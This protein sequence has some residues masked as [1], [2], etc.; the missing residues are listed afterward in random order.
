MKKSAKRSIIVSAVLAIIMCV[1]LA[2]GATFAL[3][4]SESKVNISVSSGKVNVVATVD[5][6][7]TYSGQNLTG[8]V[9]EDADKIK[10]T[11][12]L[13][14]TNGTFINGG[15]AAFNSKDANTLELTNMTPG[16]KVTF[17]I[18]VKN[19]SNVAIKY[20]T[21]IM[22]EEDNGLFDGLVID[23]KDGETTAT[24]TT[25]TDDDSPAGEA[26]EE[27]NKAQDVLGMTVISKW[28]SL[29]LD[30]DFDPDTVHVTIDLPSDRGNKY[31]DKNC[32]ISYVVEAIQGNAA[33]ENPDSTTL[34]LYS[35]RDLVKV[36]QLANAKDKS[37][38]NYTTFKLMSDVTLTKQW[39][40]IN[41]TLCK[42]AVFD[43]QGH[44]IYSMNV[45]GGSDNLGFFGTYNQKLTVKD[46][47]F[48]NAKV[49]GPSY[50]GV[51]IGYQYGQVTL[52]NVHVMNSTVETFGT[53]SG[54]MGGLIGFSGTHDGATLTLTNCSVENSKFLNGYHNTCGLVGSLAWYT[55]TPQ[56][57][58][59]YSI[60]DCVVS[61]CH[62]QWLCAANATWKGNNY[63]TCDIGAN[64]A[65]DAAFNGVTAT[66]NTYE[67]KGE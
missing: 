16:D 56:N 30:E 27:T 35:E 52:D 18:T 17:D 53:S 24:G 6:L 43:G 57:R 20:R 63:S 38:Q 23:F 36:A 5:N 25:V 4:T 28:A 7:Q 8:K 55:T 34:Y 10:L 12:E 64:V 26:T 37:I 22:C 46:L 61:G 15:K 13:G 65:Y 45:S 44:T 9:D 2:A 21:I 19:D 59:S 58:G 40:P 39:T 3:F 29:A 49:Y 48:S 31:Q 66:D 32:T 50:M 60:S 1:S 33:T 42:G 47:T 67:Y 62:F 11:T 14:G 41:E 51:V 54:H